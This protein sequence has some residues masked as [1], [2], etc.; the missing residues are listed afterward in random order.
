M[1]NDDSLT[2]EP[3]INLFTPEEEMVID[4]DEEFEIQDE[5]PQK[6]SL[7]ITRMSEKV[8]GQEKSKVESTDKDIQ[9]IM[10]M[11]DDEEEEVEEIDQ[12]TEEIDQ[13]VEEVDEIDQEVEEA[14]D[15]SH[16]VVEDIVREDLNE[17]EIEE[18]EEIEEDDLDEIEIDEEEIEELQEIQELDLNIKHQ[19]EKSKEELKVDNAFNKLDKETVSA[20]E[21]SSSELEKNSENEMERCTEDALKD[22][23]VK[24]SEIIEEF[25]EEEIKNYIRPEQEETNNIEAEKQV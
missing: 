8:S 14:E 13:E 21:I 18:N 1:E 4:E 12:E 2:M 7:E 3:D 19:E 10:D 23:L 5:D 24:D 15:I 16:E 17:I 6:E 22:T 9:E 25:E 11:E 20:K